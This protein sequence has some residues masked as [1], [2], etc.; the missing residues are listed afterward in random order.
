VT[1]HHLPA[2]IGG[3]IELPTADAL[4]NPSQPGCTFESKN[5]AGVGVAFYVL[6]ALRSELR[7]RGRFTAAAQ[8]KLDGL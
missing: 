2:L 6:L 3:V 8:P 4:V 5:L 1:D 7:A